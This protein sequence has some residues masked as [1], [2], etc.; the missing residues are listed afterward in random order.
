MQGLS[1][2]RLRHP[3]FLAPYSRQIK[4]V[5]LECHV[6]FRI[7][8]PTHLRLTYAGRIWHPYSWVRV[9][10]R[11]IYSSRDEYRGC[12]GGGYC[13]NKVTVTLRERQTEPTCTDDT[14]R[15]TKVTKNNTQAYS[16]FY[17]QTT[18]SGASL[19]RHGYEMLITSSCSIRE[20]TNV[21]LA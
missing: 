7:S 3:G 18:A 11:G 12:G 5:T 2:W 8:T 21:I 10:L 15:Q 9:G 17:G 14:G 20:K 6:W 13:A 19:R 16:F 1:P 4:K